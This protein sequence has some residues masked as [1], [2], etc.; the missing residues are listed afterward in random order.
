[1][2]AVRSIRRRT[3]SSM[4]RLHCRKRICSDLN[5]QQQKRLPP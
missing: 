5:P 1:M 4:R 2:S 3:G